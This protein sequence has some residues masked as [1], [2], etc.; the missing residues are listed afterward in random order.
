MRKPFDNAQAAKPDQ[1]RP[2]LARYP[3]GVPATL[4]YPAIA[5]WGLLREAARRFPERAAYCYYSQTATYREVWERSLQT[6]EVLKNRGVEP[7]D[8]VALLMPNIPEY[9]TVLNGIWLA[10][11]RA[12]GVSPL[13][14]AEEVSEL[15]KATGCRVAVCL[16]M[17]APL[18]L[19][20]PYQP[21]Q[22]L[23]VTLRDCLPRWQQIGYVFARRRSTGRWWVRE[24]DGLRWL[25]DELDSATGDIDPVQLEPEQTPA[26]ILPTGGTTG[27]PKAVVLSHRN[28]VANAWQQ[29]HWSGVERG[30]ETVLAVLPFFHSYGLSATL[31]TGVTMAATLVMHHRFNTRLAIRLIERHRP[32]IFHAV[33][34]MLT[35]MNERLR[36]KPA[37]LGSLRWCIS[38]G[39]P[40]P[41]SVAEEFAEHSGATVVEGYGLSEASPVT[42][43]GP[44]DGTARPGTI[45]LPLPDTDARIVD[46]QTG[47]QTLPPSAVGELIV[48]G[49]QVMLGYWNDPEQTRHAI[50]D[51]WLFTGDLAA[52]DP[53][54]F[55]RIVDRKKDL[56]ITSGFNV[57]PGDVEEVLKRHEEIKDAAVIGVPDA[58]RGQ[59]VKALV[60]LRNGATL[61]ERR[62]HEYCRR[63]LGAHKRPRIIEIIEGDLPRNFL[64]K[65]LRRRLREAAVETAE[66]SSDQLAL[67][68]QAATTE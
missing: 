21:E 47:T 55:F 14:V 54:G 30:Q 68:S 60:V 5:A 67:G 10:G 6:A 32:T 58:Q 40:L 2:W 4:E 29:F 27:S 22:T 65:V 9:L 20:G 43:V 23:L 37:D 13:M 61:D 52:C 8:R 50:R 62:L 51:G 24:S 57:Y 25:D 56:I 42:H 1:S 44:L 46:A 26:Y 28:L 63:H 7:G 41:Q 31:M 59:V 35:A 49:P 15:L 16:D 12:V 45:G 66:S 39:A 36:H 17:L 19:D 38:G 3:C 34:A 64:G 48:R 33:P 53:D 18:V 11:G